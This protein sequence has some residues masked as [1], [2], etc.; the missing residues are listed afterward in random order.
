MIARSRIAAALGAALTFGAAGGV[1]LAAGTVTPPAGTPNLAAMVVQSA[2]LAPGAVAAQQGYVTPPKNFSAQ[3]DAGFTSAATS[4]GVSY[5]SISDEVAIAPS[6]ATVGDFVGLET[7]LLRTKAGHKLL[8][9]VIIK[10]AGRKAH[11]KAKDIKYRALGSVGVGQTS[12]LETIGVAS[13]HVSV[14]E[15]VVLF[16]EGTVYGSVTLTAKPG[17][18]IPQSDATAL[19]SAMD[20]HVD[21]N[22][23]ATGATGT[24]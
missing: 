24:T 9:R 21:A 14:H 6:A 12:F 18:Q 16:Q 15:D 20:A 8:D 13:R 1:A 5:Y 3:Y 4:D 19:A 23:G 7:Q 10:V 2:D 17:E 11:L 22:V